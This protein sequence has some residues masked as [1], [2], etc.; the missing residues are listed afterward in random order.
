IDNDG[1]IDI[2]LVPN[3]GPAALLINEGG[4]RGNWLQFRL[5]GRQSNRDGIG[6]R[7]DVTANG[8]TMRDEVRAAYSYCSAND[9]RA[10]FALGGATRTRQVEIRWP[11]GHI[12][13]FTNVAANRIYTVTEGEGLR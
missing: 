7:I 12:D 1:D 13:R 6:A 4:N 5:R 3:E 11:S 8:R 9:L 2:L 10:H